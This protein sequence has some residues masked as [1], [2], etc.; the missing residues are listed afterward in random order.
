MRKLLLIICSFSLI[1]GLLLAQSFGPTRPCDSLWSIAM[2]AR[3]NKQVSVSQVI[4]GIVKKNPSA[5]YGRN[6]NGLRIGVML[7]LPTLAEI[8]HVSAVKAKSLMAKQIKAWPALRKKLLARHEMPQVSCAKKNTK[9]DAVRAVEV[10]KTQPGQDDNKTSE[11]VNQTNELKGQMTS[12]TAQVSDLTAQSN[13][14]IQENQALTAQLTQKIEENQI[15]TAQLTRIEGESQAALSAAKQQAQLIKDTLW[16]QVQALQ[17]NLQTISLHHFS[18]IVNHLS[19]NTMTMLSSQQGSSTSTLMAQLLSNTAMPIV[20]VQ[21]SQYVVSPPFAARLIRFT[22]IKP[23]FI[24]VIVL[25][26]LLVLLIFIRVLNQH[27]REAPTGMTS[28]VTVEESDD[29]QSA[30]E[31]ESLGGK[32]K[33]PSYQYLSGENVEASKLDLGK[34]LIEMGNVDHAKE[35]LNSVLEEGDENQKAEA[36]K[37]LKQISQ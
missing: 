12:L 30:G 24:A 23:L 13:Q 2:Q 21:P 15:L 28:K 16:Q 25:L 11:L 9:N 31:T 29:K 26:I 36:Q 19:S 17:K 18:K 14:K 4:I 7:R 35:V 34:A 3:P 37:L 10:S 33:T 6:L 8:N 32:K 1:P 22:T 5:F 20:T 27:R